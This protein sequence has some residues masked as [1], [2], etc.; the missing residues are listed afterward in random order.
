[1]QHRTEKECIFKVKWQEGEVRDKD[2]K[3]T[4]GK[5]EEEKVVEGGEERAGGGGLLFGVF[6]SSR[7]WL[8]A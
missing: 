8:G 3:E 1:M 2:G 6:E 4:E 5:E 7:S